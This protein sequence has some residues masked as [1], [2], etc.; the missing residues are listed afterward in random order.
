MSA[1]DCTSYVISSPFTSGPVLSRIERRAETP[2]L[3][4]PSADI[5]IIQ[6]QLSIPTSD[7][8]FACASFTVHEPVCRPF[9]FR[10]LLATQDG[11]L[12]PFARSHS[13]WKTSFLS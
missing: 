13:A 3:P 7:S 2:D 4:S 5:S 12:V 8:S 10:T 1:A 9:W 11:L 6:R